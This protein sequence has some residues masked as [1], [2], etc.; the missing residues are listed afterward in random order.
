MLFAIWL[1]LVTTNL[2]LELSELMQSL[3]TGLSPSK[4]DLLSLKIESIFN[5]KSSRESI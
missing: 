2:S 4:P 3:N 5:P 1:N